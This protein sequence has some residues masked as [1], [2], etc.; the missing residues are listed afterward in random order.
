MPD[1]VTPYKGLTE[2]TVGADNNTWGGLLNTDLSLIDTAFGG[3]VAVSISGITTS[4]TDTQAQSTGFVFTGSLTGLNTITWPAFY[5]MATINNQTSGGYT[6]SCGISG[7][8]YATI[9]WGEI[10][11]IWSDGTNF[12]RL[13]NPQYPGDMKAVA[14]TA[15]PTG[16]LYC[17]GSAVSR[18]TY[19]GLFNKIMTTFGSGD[20]STTFNLPDMRGRVPAGYDNGNET[21]RLTEVTSQGV[22]AS[23]L[24][25]TGGEQAHT[26]TESELYPHTHTPANGKPF[27]LADDATE[28]S[29]GTSGTTIYEPSI[30]SLTDV[31]GGGAFNVVQPS[32][33]VGWVIKT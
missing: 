20:G 8:S 14:Y 12:F 28:I 26:Q 6:L 32:L 3:T 4:I 25:N 13:T 18:T 31:G 9:L 2:P 23:T 30:T 11:A 29:V 5:G 10:T 27:V 33:I 19:A 22:S 21:G 7:G 24:G 17:D 1:L 15:A 16:W